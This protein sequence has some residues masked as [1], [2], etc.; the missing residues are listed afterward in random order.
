VNE[1]DGRFWN[2]KMKPRAAIRQD[3]PLP[4]ARSGEPRLVVLPSA[5]PTS[6]L[7]PLALGLRSPGHIERGVRVRRWLL[8][9]ADVMAM[10]AALLIGLTGFALNRGGFVFLAILPAVVLVF[11]IAGLYNLDELRLDHTTLDEAP[12]LLEVIALL[13]L[14]TV[15]LVPVF[16]GRALGAARLPLFSVIAFGG[17]FA[18]RVL[19]RTTTRRVLPGERCLI[20]GEPREAA[21]VRDRIAA[22]RAK[23]TIVDEMTGVDIERLGGSE[24]IAGLVEDLVIDRIIIIAR[25]GTGS[26]DV[27]ELLRMVKAVG[28]RTSV[29]PRFLEVAGAGVTFD[30]VEGL[31]MLGVPHLGLCRTSRALKRALDIAATTLGLMLLTPV[32]IVIAVAI[33]FDSRGPVFFRQMR[34]GR[35]SRPFYIVK[36]RSMVTDA[37]KRKEELRSFSVAGEGLFKIK[38]D[39]RVT[40]VGKFLRSTSLDE[41]PQL[42]NVLRGEMSLVGPRPLVPDED[43]QVMGLHRSRL[44]LK[45]GMTG[46]WQTLGSR[47]ALAEMVEIDYL[48]ASH[49]SLWADCKIL[50]RTVQ[51]VLR[52][53]N[54]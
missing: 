32:L 24:A 6:D 37:E 14:A 35:G 53:G 3:A 34:I 38:D 8:T 27:A 5:E 2:E 23:T 36:F 15:I 13:V 18:G 26:D 11:K 1:P 28:V 41:L 43:A 7:A 10:A 19:V 33:R 50:L 44:R 45:P 25:H 20:I 54:L 29:L 30:Q 42:F 52:R 51:H 12:L 16:G 47:V 22:S 49:W 17:V 21:R 46:P 48:Y 40:R 31:P 4:D 9:G 39:P